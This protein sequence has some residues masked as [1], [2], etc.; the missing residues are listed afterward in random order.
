MHHLDHTTELVWDDIIQM[1]NVGCV[2]QS[3][4]G[5]ALLFNKPATSCP[6]PLPREECRAPKKK[7]ETCETG[8]PSVN[9]NNNKGKKSR[10]KASEGISG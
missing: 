4:R 8:A 10:R 5:N 3:V 2:A 7:V 6:Q 9:I 1:H